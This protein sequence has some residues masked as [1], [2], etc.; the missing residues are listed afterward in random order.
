[1]NDGKLK[2]D[3]GLLEDQSLVA[4]PRDQ[5]LEDPCSQLAVAGSR[6]DPGGQ[7]FKSKLVGPSTYLGA[8]F[9]SAVD[10]G[11]R[12]R[13]KTRLGEDKSEV[14]RNMENVLGVSN[15]Q[16][17]VERTAEDLDSHFRVPGV[18]VECPKLGQARESAIRLPVDRVEPVRLTCESDRGL[19]LRPGLRQ[20]GSE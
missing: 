7:P 8:E 3:L 18:P 10:Q 17:E 1:M 12:I 5:A 6:L 15:V 4:T 19:K 16:G 11:G 13:C 20:R 2:L 9:A 14:V